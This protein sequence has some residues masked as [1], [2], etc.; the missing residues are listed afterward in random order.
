[1]ECKCKVEVSDNSCPLVISILLELLTCFFFFNF[2]FNFCYISGY[3]MF[4]GLL[5]QMIFLLFLNSWEFFIQLSYLCDSN[6][7]SLIL[8]IRLWRKSLIIFSSLFLHSLKHGWHEFHFHFK[9][10]NYPILYRC[11]YQHL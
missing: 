9:I 3:N 10:W 8:M 6:Q 11:A 4:W 2:L 1:M 5:R 7:Q